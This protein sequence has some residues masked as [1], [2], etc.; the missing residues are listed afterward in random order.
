[1]IRRVP[2]PAAHLI[3]S[4]TVPDT[5][6]TPTGQQAEPSTAPSAPNKTFSEVIA[7]VD[8]VSG[9]MT[10]AQAG[11]LWDRARELRSGD[12]IVEIGSFHGR[13]AIVLA[14]AAPEGVSITTIDPH[15]GNDRGPQEI[16]GYE[17]E[18]E[19]DHH[20]FMANLERA[21]V[22]DR[23]R[24]LR[25]YSSD[26]HDEVEGDVTLLY[27]DGAHRYT[28]AVADIRSWGAR[29]APGGV[30]LVHD[31]FSSVGVT[32]ALLATQLTGSSGFV[33][34]GRSGSMTQYRRL[35]GGVMG[36]KRRVLN[37]L[38]QISELPWFVRNLLIKVLITLRLGRLTRFLGGDGT[39]P[40]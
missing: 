5:T 33:Y 19:A 34:E 40:Y 39:W 4:S 30:M 20:Q 11:R 13:S 18:A 26:A 38:R 25:L 22:R 37:A 24:H 9:W 36:P 29:V 14:S 21:G 32:L 31:S 27:V 16:E 2:R 3:G 7:S 17:A 28:P 8:D 12:S 6:P 15:G 35:A 10:R 1:M 23:I